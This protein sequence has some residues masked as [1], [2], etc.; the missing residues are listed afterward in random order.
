MAVAEDLPLVLT[1]SEAA[2]ALRV[3]KRVIYE[4][5]RRKEIKAAHIGP[6]RIIRIRREEIDRL[7]S[8]SK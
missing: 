8:G 5:V 2:A 4:C 1:V 7:L 6:K 3:G